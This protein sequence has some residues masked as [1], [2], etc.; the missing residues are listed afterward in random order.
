MPSDNSVIPYR[1]PK[2]LPNNVG[3]PFYVEHL[4]IVQGKTDVARF[5]PDAK[6]DDVAQD[7][8]LVVAEKAPAPGRRAGRDDAWDFRA[9]G[10]CISPLVRRNYNAKLLL[11]N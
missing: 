7:G 1:R 10:V 6:C 5:P 11:V 9:P 4:D 3:S 8:W 2:S